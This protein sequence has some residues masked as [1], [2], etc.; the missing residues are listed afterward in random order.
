MN[1]SFGSAERRLAAITKACET[2]DH[3]DEELHNVELHHAA[4]TALVKL[5]HASPNDNE[6]RMI[7][8]AIEM[9]ARA[10]ATAVSAAYHRLN[11]PQF[12]QTLIRLLDR[13]EKVNVQRV[14]TGLLSISRILYSMSRELELRA[15]L[16]RQPGVLPA[17]ARV[18]TRVL[19]PDCRLC[20]MRT[21]ANL[22]H[23]AENKE[24]LLAEPGL[25]DAIL[26]VGHFDSAPPARQYAAATIAELSIAPAN[27]RAMAHNETVLGTLVKMVLVETQTA[28]TRESAMTALQNLAF[29]KENRHAL[30]V[31]RN[32]IVIEALKKALSS[33]PDTKARR[34][35]ASALTNTASEETVEVMGNHKGLLDALAIVAT[36]DENLDVQ[37]RA[38]L[39]LTKIASGITVQMEC[40]AAVLDALVVASLSQAPNSV[41]AVLRVKARF[42]ENRP[43][44]ARH[45]GILDTL[46]DICQSDTAPT[47]D[48][49]HAIRALMHLV[50]DD[51]NRALLCQPTI[52]A[53][54]VA[55][56]TVADPAL[57]EARDSAVRALERLA[58]EAT[59]RPQMARHPGLL[60]A[61][62]QAV[63]REAQWE[64]D[65]GGGGALGSDGDYLAKPLLMSLL[66]AM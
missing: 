11:G 36:K 66:L 55:V 17:L 42:P 63:E 22:A 31:F 5:L 21:L 16:C 20:R 18:S 37:A 60:A 62:A 15:V 47:A 59:N 27:Q 44:L 54:A 65:G 58:T 49:D 41:A 50:N 39:A 40:H 34:R 52:L 4:A 10:S 48:R 64:M 32:G 29:E 51:D 24:L 53:A 28:A 61:V 3:T 45:A 35:A 46:A 23:C 13:F 30:V 6:I 33:D 8:A 1:R 14:D 38:S 2:F 25:L 7:L 57:D 19:S 26:R 43:T 12:V 56:A 9:V